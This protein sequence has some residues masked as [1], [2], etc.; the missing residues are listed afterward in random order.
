[1][2]VPTVN[3][4]IEQDADFSTTFSLKR[5]DGSPLDLT[6]YNIISKMRKW[7]ESEGFVSFATTYNAN[8]TQ[9]K[10]TISLN[11]NQTGIITAGRYNYDILITNTT[12]NI[13]TKSITGQVIVNSTVS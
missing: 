11:S 12:N 1:M 4:V 2:A 13:T 8:P 10:L 7:S 3:L 9:G 6:N 5:T